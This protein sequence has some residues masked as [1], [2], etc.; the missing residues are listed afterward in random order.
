[1]YQIS[2]LKDN[3]KEFRD[4][5]KEG[6][7]FRPLSVKIKLTWKCN[8]S[9]VMCNSVRQCRE[10]LLNYKR[11][12][13]LVQELSE[14]GCKKIHF[15]GGEPLL[16]D[17][18][19]DISLYA[20]NKKHIKINLT[21]NGTLITADVAKKLIDAR[22]KTISISLDSPLAKIHDNIRGSGAWK[23]TIEGVKNLV[24][25]RNISKSKTKIRF[26][27]VIS[28]LNYDSLKKLPSLA[29]SL[30]VDFLLLI[31]VDD[32]LSSGLNLN[33][34][35][36]IEYNIEVAPLLLEEGKK[37][38]LWEWDE[39]V[40]PFG[41]TFS[42]L[43][44]SSRG[45]YS[46]GLYKH[47]PCFAPWLHSFISPRGRVFLCCMTKDVGLIGKVKKKNF[48][49]IWEGE[50]YKHLRHLMLESRFPQCFKCDSFLRENLYIAKKLLPFESQ[51]EEVLV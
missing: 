50:R 34:K 44:F 46:R 7:P 21:T 28:S 37:Y 40:F 4:C 10:S 25:E 26:N 13:K 1:M 23:K 49:E 32:H 29:G 51:K 2:C 14:L 45:L 18:L 42:D 48:Q 22:L 8:L 41:R 24:R 39:Q 36:L 16:W 3:L 31:P 19:Y 17:G 35:E 6:R 38:G 12:L 20:R 30:G 5:L 11:V 33:S 15:S 27:V 9:C 43:D 47:I